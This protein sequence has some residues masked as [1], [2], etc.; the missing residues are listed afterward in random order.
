M[1][2]LR[3]NRVLFLLPYPLHRAPSQRFR[4]EAFFPLLDQQDIQY[5]IHCF[6][7]ERAWGRLYQKGSG[8]QKA[9]AVFR[10]L[11][12]RLWVVLWVAPRFRYVFVHREAAP[13]GP[14]VF[15]WI[16]ARL[17]RRKLIYDFDDAIWIPVLSEHNKGASSA[18]CTWKVKYICRWATTVAVGNEYLAGFA[19]QYNQQV[20]LLPTCVDTVTRF[21]RLQPQNQGLP[22]IGWTGSHSTLPYLYQLVPVLQ[23]LAQQFAFELLVICNQAPAFRMKELRYLSWK[24]ASEINDLLQVNIGV[25]PLE[26]DA[27]SEGKCGFKIIQYLSLGI[28]AVASPVGVNKQIVDHGVNGYLCQSRQ[29]WYDAL[30]TLLQD[31]TLRSRMG[32]AGRRKIQAEYSIQ[33]HADTFLCLL[34]EQKP[35]GYTPESKGSRPLHQS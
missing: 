10:G 12:M 22:V 26:A 23:Q 35:M 15:E 20:V 11:L 33:A 30:A 32:A 17:L 31:A 34:G 29:E 1:L 21:N 7:D 24:E 27:W 19:R 2:K 14:P 25:M 9:W 8:L 6:L 18:R 3:N 13:V 16:L 4:V 28:P 5:Q